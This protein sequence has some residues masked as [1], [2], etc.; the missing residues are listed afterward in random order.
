MFR[1]GN[2]VTAE[3]LNA[4]YADSRAKGFGPEVCSE[5]AVRTYFNIL[6]LVLNFVV[7]FIYFKISSKGEILT[8]SFTI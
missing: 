7:Y 8:Q 2:Q 5:V 4:L 3:E 6:V 1:Y